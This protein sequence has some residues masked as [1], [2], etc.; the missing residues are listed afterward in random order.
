MLSLRHFFSI[1]LWGG[2]FLGSCLLLKGAEAPTAPPPEPPYLPEHYFPEL[3]EAMNA[4]R[5]SAPLLQEHALLEEEAEARLGQARSHRLPGAN[6]YLQAGPREEFRSGDVEDNS[7]FAVNGGLRLTQPLYHWGAIKAGIELARSAL[8]A[9]GL[10]RLRQESELLR[11]LRAD[12]LQI[13]LAQQHQLNEAQRLRVLQERVQALQIEVDAKK[14][15]NIALS[16]LRIQAERAELSAARLRHHES[17]LI[18]RFQR[19]SGRAHPVIGQGALP[20]LDPQVALAWLEAE[21][22][23]L[24][25]GRAY[26]WIPVRQHLAALEQHTSQMKIIAANNRPKFSLFLAAT[27]GVTNTATDNDVNTIAL[28]AG[29]GV[30]WNIFDGFRTQEQSIEAQLK[31]NRLQY[32]LD[33]RVSELRSEQRR[34][35]EDLRLRLREL[36]LLERSRPIRE[37]RNNEAAI[38]REAGRMTEADFQQAT[39]QL[40]SFEIELSEARVDV[41]LGISDYAS[42]TQLVEPDRSR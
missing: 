42:F 17:N 40:E 23:T 26:E 21:E 33:R 39:L 11:Q 37:A 9:S 28:T 32:Q 22:A 4:A 34:M 12:Y 27:Q 6:L 36:D 18:A 35:I 14:R 19:Q 30:N 16:D 31:K 7:F 15:S 10:E 1:C 2:A 38:A 29:V 5:N 3:A 24:D 20:E 8:D 13:L 25:T 41:L